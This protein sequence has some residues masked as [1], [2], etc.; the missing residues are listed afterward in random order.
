MFARA[1]HL[2]GW[3]LPVA[4]LCP[5][6]IWLALDHSVW[7][8]DQ[9][10]FGAHTVTLYET[11]RSDPL[12]WP[13]AM[14]ATTPLK[15][16]AVAWIGQFFVPLGL[17]MGSVDAALRLSI[18]ACHL[19]ALMVVFRALLELS[20][21][22]IPVAAAGTLVV[23][24]GPI[25]I[26]LS[27]QYLAEA[28]Q[29]LAV[30]WFVLIM[31]RAPRWR[32]S[33]IAAQ[34]VAATAFAMVAKTTSPL[35]CAAPGLIAVVEFIRRN[36]VSAT[37]GERRA[38]W[39]R[40]AFALALA[41]AATAWYVRNFETALH[42]ATVASFS[43]VA[44]FYGHRDTFLRSLDHWRR[45]ASVVFFL[46]PVSA[47]LGLIVVLGTV[48]R[49]TAGRATAIA[50]RDI[51]AAMAFLQVLVALSI[52]A[53]SPNRDPRYAAPLLPLVAVTVSWAILHSGLRWTA[54]LAVAT[55][56]VQ[57]SLAHSQ[58]LGLWPGRPV[59]LRAEL[60]IDPA[61]SRV[62]RDRRPAAV[63]EAIV[64]RTCDPSVVGREN[65]VGVDLLQL[66]GHS[67]TYAAAKER[68]AGHAGSC[69]YHSFGF[70]PLEATRWELEAREYTYWIAVDPKI[71][72][73]PAYNEFLN[74]S[75][76][77][78]FRRLRRR[79]VLEPEPWDGLKGVLLYRFVKR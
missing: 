64:H 69:R 46:Q 30:A 7:P 75:A 57:L 24:A 41:G 59:I 8:W 68:L 11:L 28:S 66:N 20:G 18:W 65:L 39:L 19:A 74:R 2:T 33:M 67:L 70:T 31:A 48:V 25:F 29:T 4:I 71:H 53:L 23:G 1:K 54:P 45:V 12:G 60:G 17:A 27:T 6:L 14:A 36:R 76:P 40:W 26:A 42:H 47:L 77:V 52:F 43:P 22:R 78:V 44:E 9:A 79:G 37:A 34:L 51:C 35:Y 32:R 49:L 55:L 73:V 63:L 15:P 16:P 13:A 56:L 10:W 38:G 3:W 21:G 5:S 62:H 61:M 50:H 72:P 58:A